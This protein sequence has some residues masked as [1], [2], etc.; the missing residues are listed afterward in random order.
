MARGGL[1]ISNSAPTTSQT[2]STAERREEQKLKRLESLQP[3]EPVEQLHQVRSR[4][5]HEGKGL[6]QLS[7]AE[8]ARAFLLLAPWPQ[9]ALHRQTATGDTSFKLIL[10]PCLP[11]IIK[12]VKM[13]LHF[14][15]Y[16]AELLHENWCLLM[17][18][19]FFFFVICDMTLKKKK[20][21]GVQSK[22]PFV[23]LKDDIL[24]V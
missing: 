18:I 12:Q 6:T 1:C 9:P 5:E 16:I 10:S 20:P 11:S 17:L 24:T 19:F 13:R 15:A 4:A 8:K 14:T 21:F 23:M 2:F 22:V 3:Q 7:R